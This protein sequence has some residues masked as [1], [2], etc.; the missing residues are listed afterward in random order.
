MDEE[1]RQRLAPSLR[2]ELERTEHLAETLVGQSESNALAA[3]ELAGIIVRVAA[4]DG[5]TFM[6]RKDLRPS[7]VN[8]TIDDGKVIAASVG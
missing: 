2:R 8:V 5:K 4:R 3:A 1:A 6:L 7:R